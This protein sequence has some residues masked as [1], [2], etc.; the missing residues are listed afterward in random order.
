[1][2]SEC[3][4]DD[5]LGA[6]VEDAL[7][8]TE[9]A[10]I[11]AHL[12]RCDACLA[13]VVAVVRGGARAPDETQLARGTPS[14]LPLLEMAVARPLVG[15]RLGRYQIESLLGTGGMGQVFAAHDSEL[16]RTIALKVLRP[17]VARAAST[18]AERLIRE[19]RLMAKIA[20]PSVIGVHD[21]G[22]QGDVVFVAMEMI[23]GETLGA[24]V[25]RTRPTWREAAALYERAGLG[26]AAAHDA[27]I[28]H[29][30]FKPDNVLVEG[31]GARVVVTDFGI[32]TAAALADVGDPT[33]ATT[34]DV[35]LTQTGVAIGTPAY[36][37]PEQL[38]GGIVDHRA[39]VFAF[40][41]S[42]WEALFGERPFRGKTVDEI[43]AAMCVV[44]K[45]P[46][47]RVPRRLVRALERAL[48]IDP[49]RRWSDMRALL[50][51]LAAARSTRGRTIAAAV[52]GGVGLVGIGITAALVLGQRA[53]LD[54]CAS[55]RDALARSAAL[56][57]EVTGT[58]DATT[59]Q[60]LEA[61]VAAWRDTHAAT[62][63]AGRE[64]A[65]LPTVAACLEARKLELDG[66]LET[67]RRDGAKAAPMAALMVDPRRCKDPHAGLLSSR[68]PADPA[69]RE[70]VAG[71]R[72]RAF[73]I[74]AA[75]D[76]AEYAS[77][78]ADAKVLVDTQRDL[79]PPLGA[80]LLY[81]LGTTQSMGGDNS[82]AIATLREA[83]ALAERSHHSYVAA[84]SWVQLIQAE[85]FDD[86]DP[87]RA[88]E[89][90][91]YADAAIESIG[92]PP[93]LEL[94]YLYY[95]GVAMIEADQTKEAEAILRRCVD[96][97]IAKAPDYLSQAMFGLGY[98]LEEQ[99]R[100]AEA[101]ATYRRAI[102][103]LE[104][105]KSP[106]SAH[107]FRERLAANLALL[108]QAA[109]AEAIA[110]EAVEIAD[111]TLGDD[112]LDRV[113]VRATLAQVLEQTGKFDEALVQ[114]RIAEELF[115]KIHG[116]RHE[117]Y[118][119]L[120]TLE[121][122]ILVETER[123]AEATKVLSRACEVIAFGVGEGSTQHAECALNLG[124]A[125][126][127][128]G[129]PEEAL[130]VVE[131]AVD[132]IL[133]VDGDHTPRGASALVRRGA[134]RVEVGRRRQGIADLEQAIASFATQQLEPG[135]LADAKWVL[136]HALWKTDRARAR[137]LIEEAIALF[138]E[139]S[140]SWAATKAE[141][142]AWLRGGGHAT[143]PL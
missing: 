101:A 4:S 6:L 51:E 71:V 28:V 75:R 133:E 98:L 70:R 131:P 53:E 126:D 62:C 86:G 107:T 33:H 5:Q 111:K 45:P 78:I 118:G 80:E 91:T 64:P 61:T 113:T 20:H 37:A 29:R 110:R 82:H 49:A 52:A 96:L 73:A 26:L 31:D 104:K 74:E 46:R 141:A 103:E 93:D 40:A 112:N 14:V 105:S 44:P 95:K 108:N 41:V 30:D 137:A 32:A 43:R 122:A 120:R 89:Y 72:Y 7:D 85:A 83:A 130:A 139:A 106:T 97:A 21:V 63:R 92:R 99:G 88:L 135:H 68:V 116:E 115:V 81:L 77:A 66:F 140:A 10:R 16:D 76:R 109:E 129:R 3:P 114:V 59:Q 60:R 57:R 90:A 11:G 56:A 2:T 17:E 102:H 18:L 87:K 121:G 47:A 34:K 50:R 9:A 94:L 48:S 25:A 13:I 22:R 119:E 124:V 69:L 35:R 39:D 12:D 127:G 19:S 123:Y 1:M 100:Y 125:L 67:A 136:G 132:A 128:I 138:D 8:A 65:Q 79:W 58:L 42:L 27:G 23:E 15:T 55:K 84:N 142:V 54:P 38:D 36:M 143:T 117:H 134:L 24:F